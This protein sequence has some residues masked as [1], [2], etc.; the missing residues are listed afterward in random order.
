MSTE[1]Y[2][3]IVVGA[4]ISGLSMAHYGKRQGLNVLLLEQSNSPGGL[5][6]SQR[7][8]ADFWVELGAHSCYNSYGQVIEI[9]DD[10]GLLSQLQA[11]Q[12]STFRVW[13]AGGL[14]SIPS[15]LH[16]LEL[17][18]SLPKLLWTKKTG[19]S[20]ASYYTRLFGT[21]NYQSVFKHAFNAVI[22]QAADEMPAD[23]L[24]RKKPRHKTVMRSFTLPGGLQTLT[25]RLAS[26]LNCRTDTTVLSL[27][28][29]A[30]QF[31]VQTQAGHRYQSRA[32]CLATPVTITARLL[33]TAFPALAT[34][35]ADI[36]LAPSESLGLY[37]PKAACPLETLA[38]VIGID[39]DFYSLVS[40]DPIPN[41]DWRGFTWHF[42]PGLALSDKIAQ[43]SQLLGVDAAQI[44]GTASGYNALPSL[45]TGHAARIAQLDHAL[46]DLP[47][48]ITGNYFQ[49][50][51]IEDAVSR[52][53]SEYQRLFAAKHPKRRA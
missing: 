44:T 27:D 3:L 39:Q 24:F 42:K 51:S 9:L 45:R 32:L 11:K 12:N 17:L 47:L 20:V 18:R 40:R 28:Y 38:G 14:R 23:A 21:R 13:Q 5:I 43:A 50:V 35:L 37:L 33:Q 31:Q 26:Q 25:D 36:P 46:A 48:G 29:Q 19:Q 6:Q 49:G 1:I 10:L 30:A 22:C 52:S 8:T 4:G 7:F 41:P 16:W 2:D 34:L 53:H 15:Q